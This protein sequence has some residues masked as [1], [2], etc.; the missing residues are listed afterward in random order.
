MAKQINEEEKA[1]IDKVQNALDVIGLIPG[2][3]EF[4][5]GINGLISI[6]RGD[7]TGAALSFVS[8]VPGIGDVVGK[9]GK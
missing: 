3:G 6:G 1:T 4:A 8:M 9:G 2:I 7:M 5:D